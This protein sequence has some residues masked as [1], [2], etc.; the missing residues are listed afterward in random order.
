MGKRASGRGKPA[1]YPLNP[2]RRNP[3][4]SLR[5]VSFSRKASTQGQRA[6]QYF[7]RNQDATQPIDHGLAGHHRLHR[8]VKVLQKRKGNLSDSG[9]AIKQQNLGDKAAKSGYPSSLTVPPLL[10]HPHNGSEVF[11]QPFSPENFVGK[12]DHLD[13]T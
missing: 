9:A 8:F 3:P 11:L 1:L 12:L 13:S 5:F 2:R 7:E 6:L 4:F 10:I